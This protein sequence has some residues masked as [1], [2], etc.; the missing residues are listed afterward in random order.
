MAR[1]CSRLWS[2]PLA[3]LLLALPARSALA[4][5]GSV[6]GKVTDAAGA[7]IGGVRVVIVGTTLEVQ[8]PVS[9]EYRVTNVRAGRVVVRVFKLGFKSG[10]DSVTLSPGG[11]VTADFQLAESLVSL[12]EV[13]VT[14][15]AGNQERRAQSAQVASLDASTLAAAQPRISTV[16]G[17]LQSRSPASR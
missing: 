15:T 1:M 9:G 17:M 7:P 3:L 12:S 13:V 16:G 6:T 8:T 10:I 4:Q 5:T 2:L 11:T 14:G